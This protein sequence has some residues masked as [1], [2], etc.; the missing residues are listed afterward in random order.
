MDTSDN[1]QAA[2][3]NGDAGNAWV[4]AQAL[5][6]HMFKPIEAMLVDAVSAER[7]QQVLDIGCGTGSTTIAASRRLGTKGHC[8]GGDIS[9]QMIAMARTRAERESL[10]T[11]FICADAQRHVFDPA[12]F[13]LIISRFGVMFFN[14]AVAAFENLRHAARKNAECRFIAWRGAEENPFMTTAERAAT[15]L[16]PHMPARDPDGPGQFAF[17]RRE[18]VGSILDESGWDAIHI[19]PVDVTCTFPESELIHYLTRMGPLG[20]VLNKMDEPSRKNVVEKVRTAFDPYVNGDEVSYTAACW[21][22]SARAG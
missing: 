20:R 1:E 17:A 12:S 18:R 6:D 15:T 13:D 2:I 8:V 7:H 19:E 14:D 22:V 11:T 5:L 3:W 21:N 9:E 10:T 16:L 4:E